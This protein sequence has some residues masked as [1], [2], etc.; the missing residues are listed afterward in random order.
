MGILFR[1]GRLF[2]KKDLVLAN[3]HIV[4]FVHAIITANW[5]FLLVLSM[6]YYQPV[7]VGNY[8]LPID[9]II[10]FFK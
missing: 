10:A 2:R 7:S 4:Y 6:P 8:H 9:S 5:I 1:E 3:L